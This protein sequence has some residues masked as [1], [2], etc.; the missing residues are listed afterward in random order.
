ME[1]FTLSNDRNI[2]HAESL[3][4]ETYFVVLKND[5]SVEVRKVTKIKKKWSK[6]LA[7]S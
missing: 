7:I 1:K 2:V 6:R 5:N 3:P 4:A